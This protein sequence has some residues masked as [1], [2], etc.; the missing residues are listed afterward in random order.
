MP[1]KRKMGSL[2]GT[3]CKGST[4]SFILLSS[5]ATNLCSPLGWPVDSGCTGKFP[6]LHVEMQS[7]FTAGETD[8][9]KYHGLLWLGCSAKTGCCSK[10]QT[11]EL[12]C[13]ILDRFF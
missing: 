5:F 7:G 4:R 2:P 8:V 1:N 11:Q 6:S 13:A 3:L 10:R 9:A 12:Q